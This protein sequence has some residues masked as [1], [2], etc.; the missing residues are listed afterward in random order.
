MFSLACSILFFYMT[1]KNISPADIL[2]KMQLTFTDEME[3]SQ[4]TI[5]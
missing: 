5:C 2:T 1:Y 4:K 3:C